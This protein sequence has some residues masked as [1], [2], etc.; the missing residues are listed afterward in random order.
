L[1]E[2]QKQVWFLSQMAKGVGGAYHESVT[3]QLR[4]P[5]NL[6]AIK[7]AVNKLVERHE[8]LRTT[9]SPEGDYQRIRPFVGVQIPLV[10]FSHFDGDKQLAEVD[11]WIAQEVQQPFD[12]VEGPLL[13]VRVLKL[14]PEYHYV[15]ITT[16]HLITDG[17]SYGVLLKEL[18][19]LYAAE[20][21]GVPCELPPMM[22]FSEYAELQ[23]SWQASADT[24][25]DEEY[26][27][28]QFA[29]GFPILELPTDHPR[30]KQRSNKGARLRA[31]IGEQ[32]TSDLKRLSGR[33]G[34]T[35]FT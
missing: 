17:H 22:Q 29:D 3:M 6:N 14:E 12:L 25:A 15:V 19:A 8:V 4:G 16:H 35:M 26:W 28:Q 31:T 2:V 30:T 32:L 21:Q 13:R 9:F 10:D 7:V 5:F 20:C 27:Q 24:S 23:A 34:C 18:S 11:E 1:T 33:Q